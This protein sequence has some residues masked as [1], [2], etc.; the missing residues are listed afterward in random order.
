[1]DDQELI[2]KKLKYQSNNRGCKETDI[3]LGSFS[4]KY[5]DD[6]SDDE[7]EDYKYFLSQP[8]ADI[9]NWVSEKSH[10]KDACCAKIISMIK[11]CQ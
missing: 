4:T 7:L 2:R 6:M 5:L 9:W 8:D 3:I 10:P 11:K 1:M